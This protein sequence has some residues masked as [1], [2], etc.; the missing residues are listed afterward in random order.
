M[1]AVAQ[2]VRAPAC[3]AGCRE[4]DSRQP[5]HMKWTRN[6]VFFFITLKHG[7]NDKNI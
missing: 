4:F 6:C 5:P 2:L 1:A 3:D 7:Y